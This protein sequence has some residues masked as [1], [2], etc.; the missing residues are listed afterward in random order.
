MTAVRTYDSGEFCWTDLGTTDPAA[1]KRFYKSLFGATIEDLPMGPGS[2]KYSMLR[3]S[4]KDTAAVYPMSQKGNA[5]PA[6]IP[7]IAVRSATRTVNK[8]K[9]AGG[10]ILIAPMDVMDKGRVAVIVDPSGATIGIWQARAFPGAGLAN[11][12]GTVTWHDLNASKRAA[13]SKFYSKVFGWKQSDRKIGGKPY[14]VFTLKGSTVGGMWPEPAKNLPPCWITH[15]N[16]DNCTQTAV[17]AKKLGGRV[18]MGP[19]GVPGMGQFALIKDPQGAV[20]GIIGE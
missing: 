10:T 12:P 3:V 19:L 14:H 5:P 8:A 18:F 9:E 15:W 6:W 16:V 20:F 2:E 17:K 4:G 13:A 7:Y 11:K 1:A